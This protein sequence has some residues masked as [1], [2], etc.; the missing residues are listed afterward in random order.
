MNAVA[1]G[2]GLLIGAVIGLVAGM[3]LTFDRR[4]QEQESKWESS[5]Q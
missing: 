1:F 2:L 3:V 5:D 4:I